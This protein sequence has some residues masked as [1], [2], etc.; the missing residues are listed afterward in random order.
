MSRP[1]KL[2]A[3]RSNRLGDIDVIYVTVM[4]RA[5]ISAGHDPGP[6]L[7]RYRLP[8]QLLSTP[9]ARLSI[10]RFMRLG[11][12]AITLT[13]NPAFGLTFGAHTR[14]TDMGLAGLAA[15]CAPTLGDAL[16]TLI[17]FERL[18]SYNSRGQ[19]GYHWNNQ[20]DLEARFYSISPYNRYNAFVVDAILAGWL[21]FLRQLGNL[22]EPSLLQQVRIEY[23]QP[24]HGSLF[25]THFSCPVQFAAR[26]NT[27]VLLGDIATSPNP[28]AQPAAYRDLY[29]RCER[30]KKAMEAGWSVVERVRDELTPRLRGQAATM[31]QVAAALGTTSWGL[32]REL[33]TQGFTYRQLVDRVRSEL[34]LDYVRET[35]LSFAEI[36]YLLGFA[37]ATGFYRAFR[38]WSGT[39]PGAVRTVARAEKP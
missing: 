15:L 35:T 27:L 7:Q 24:L 19:S 34:A 23:P 10:P 38:R 12:E 31:A 11:H 20:G 18:T 33:A 37:N 30:E 36:G 4:A 21:A 2:P 5:L 1:G 8:P 9:G 14:F 32:R 28:L 13:G 22:Q 26:D 16:V 6:L 29:Q 39:N 25:E 17:R 3:G